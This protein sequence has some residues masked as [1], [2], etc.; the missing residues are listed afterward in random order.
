M[1][2]DCILTIQNQPFMILDHTPEENK[3][4]EFSQG[5]IFSKIWT[6][7]Q[8]VFLFLSQ[9]GANKYTYPLLIL[10]GISRAFTYAHSKSMGD[11]WSLNEVLSYCIVLG[12][13]LGCV[14]FYL[15]AAGLNITGKW[16]GGNSDAKNLLKVVA[17]AMYPLAISPVLVLIEIVLFDIGAFQLSYEVY[18]YDS[19]IRFLFLGMVIIKFILSIW[20]LVLLI[21]G[22]SVVQKISIAKAI[23][24]LILPLIAMAV[25]LVL[26]NMFSNR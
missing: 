25:P 23:L 22:I 19:S 6:S 17:Y 9:S 18:N 4:V 13:I 2:K 8:K 16:L 21:I 5:E 11:Y 12:G 20:S 7:P 3:I 10:A 15:F 1:F 14:F 24:N 26:F